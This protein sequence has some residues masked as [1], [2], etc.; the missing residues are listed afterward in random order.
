ML[1]SSQ[2]DRGYDLVGKT[3]KCIYLADS[4]GTFQLVDN[5]AYAFRVG[6]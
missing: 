6:F 4:G 5:I 3:N 2:K 1:V